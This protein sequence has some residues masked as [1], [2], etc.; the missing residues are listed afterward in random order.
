VDN[1]RRGPG[2]GNAGTRLAEFIGDMRLITA[3]LTA[4][5]FFTA[6][7]RTTPADRNPDDSGSDQAK[8]RKS[9]PHKE[10]R[11]DPEPEWTITV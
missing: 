1:L 9:R 4:L 7:Q 10:D 3:L 11:D 2:L 5:C 8:V 6:C